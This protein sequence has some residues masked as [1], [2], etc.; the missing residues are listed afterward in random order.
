M[1]RS[2]ATSSFPELRS[3]VR[4]RSN[5]VDLTSSSAAALSGASRTTHSGRVRICESHGRTSWPASITSAVLCSIFLCSACLLIVKGGYDGS[6]YPIT[7]KEQPSYFPIA[8][9][10]QPV[11]LALHPWPSAWALQNFC[12]R[13]LRE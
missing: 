11:M 6:S 2:N 5:R 8:V 10:A 7:L 1:L 13:L 12:T 9:P 4:I 3:L